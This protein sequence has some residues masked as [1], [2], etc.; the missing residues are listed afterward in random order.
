VPDRT[1]RALAAYLQRR[2]PVAQSRQLFLKVVV[3]WSAKGPTGVNAVVRRACERTELPDPGTHR[4]RHAAASELLRRVAQLAEIG[5]LL[6]ILSSIPSMADVG[7]A[8]G[9]G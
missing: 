4:L 8:L 2:G 5:Q 1:G 7:Q 3:P 6:P 9:N